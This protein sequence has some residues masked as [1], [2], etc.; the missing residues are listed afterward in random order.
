MHVSP[1]LGTARE[2]VILAGQRALIALSKLQAR[3]IDNA[4]RLT[5]AP[6][7]KAAPRLPGKFKPKKKVNL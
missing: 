2:A 6:V 1:V 4:S 5:D 3:A 7:S